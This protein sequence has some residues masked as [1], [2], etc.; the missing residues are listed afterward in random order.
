MWCGYLGPTV[1]VRVRVSMAWVPRTIRVRVRLG[2]VWC[3]YLGTTVRVRIRVR[4]RGRVRGRDSVFWV[5]RN[6]S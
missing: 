3:G 2:K 5:P 6:N 4:V 1:R